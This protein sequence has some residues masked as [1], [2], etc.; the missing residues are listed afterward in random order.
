M[1]NDS[2]SQTGHDLRNYLVVTLAYWGFTLTDG[3]IRMLVVLYFYQQG[4][5]PLTIAMLFVFYELAGVF[6]NFLGGWLASRTGLSTTMYMGMGLQVAA[7]IMLAVPGSWMSVPYVMFVQA[8]SGVAKDLN[9]MS[10]KSSVKLMLPENAEGKLF[11]WVALLTGSKNSIKGLGFFVGGVLL[12]VFGFQMALVVLAFFLFVFLVAAMIL[13]PKGKG[14]A[15][16]KVKFRHLF[17]KSHAINKL[18]AARLFLFAARDIWFVVALPVYLSSV[19]NW[20]HAAV[21]AFFALWIIGYGFVQAGTPFFIRRMHHHQGPAG[22]TATLWSF[23][24]F[25][26]LAT[27]AYLFKAG[28]MAESV[29]IVGLSIF[30]FVFA[31]NSAVHSYLILAYSSSD[32]VSVD[33]GF[34]YMA[35]AMGRLVG[36]VL[37]GW[38]YQKW[39]FEACLWTAA[40]FV[41]ICTTISSGLISQK[42]QLS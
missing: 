30:A 33:V 4:Y 32:Q 39:G 22:D 12:S 3:A 8:L 21:G 18:S 27:M 23:I 29:I 10:A 19:L 5:S 9:K 35:N 36:T 24:L 34:Y 6:T 15:K 42:Q 7:L 40:G 16:S 20:S 38:I 28:Y 11:K 1:M 37:S 41:L 17:S 26:V 2:S 31:V 25:L 13:L 14:K